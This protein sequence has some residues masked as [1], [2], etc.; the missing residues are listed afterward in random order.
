MEGLVPDIMH[1]ILEGVLPFELK[2]LVKFLISEKVITLAEVNDAICSFPYM[3]VDVVNKP[4]II[5]TSTLC[6]TD[7]SL[8]QT[9]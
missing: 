6:S 9:G 2:D 3:F 4:N 5:E 1:D 8:K 7:H